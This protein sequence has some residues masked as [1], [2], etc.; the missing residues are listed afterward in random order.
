MPSSRVGL[1]LKILPTKNA[2]HIV[3]VWLLVNMFVCYAPNSVTEH[4]P[5]SVMTFLKAITV[6]YEQLD[7]NDL[8]KNEG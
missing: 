5:E 6:D 3:I 1:L 7:E 4:I 2:R 8:E